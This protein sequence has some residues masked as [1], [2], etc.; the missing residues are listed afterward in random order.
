MGGG[1]EVVHLKG[2]VSAYFLAVR[3][4]KFLH[5][6]GSGY[7]PEKLAGVLTIKLYV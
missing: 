5:N 3:E 4:L 2:L 7:T 6:V 1:E